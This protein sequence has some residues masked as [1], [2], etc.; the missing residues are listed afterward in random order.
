MPALQPRVRAI[1]R[2]AGKGVVNGGR[3]D[4]GVLV[5]RLQH[6]QLLQRVQELPGR[7]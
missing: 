5:K 3:L 2:A 1:A 6:A 7:G 4:D